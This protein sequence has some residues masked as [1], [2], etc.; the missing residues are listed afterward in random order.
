MFNVRSKYVIL[1]TSPNKSKSG[2]RLQ[3]LY[4]ARRVEKHCDWNQA[5]GCQ[6]ETPQ[7]E[8]KTPHI[9]EKSSF[10]FNCLT[11][12]RQA[13]ISHIK[14]GCNF[15]VILQD[16]RFRFPNYWLITC[17]FTKVP[18][19]WQIQEVSLCQKSTKLCHNRTFL[20]ELY[21]LYSYSKT[22]TLITCSV[23]TSWSGSYGL[24]DKT[25]NQ[26]IFFFKCCVLEINS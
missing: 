14:V 26:L 4:H 7:I 9:E 19:L 13:K 21:F 2:F 8:G 10:R 22:K 24:K 11:L 25:D 17:R 12:S 16:T 18:F 5:P 20:N 6:R 1:P 23:V 15:F 3:L